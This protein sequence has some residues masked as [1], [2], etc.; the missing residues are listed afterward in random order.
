VDPAA[1]WVS[2]GFVVVGL[3]AAIVAWR[4]ERRYSARHPERRR[5][6]ALVTGRSIPLLIALVV[7]GVGVR[8]LLS[9]LVLPWWQHRAIAGGFVLLMLAT[10]A[11]SV[12]WIRRREQSDAT[13]RVATR[14]LIAVVVLA[15][16]AFGFAGT[17]V[18]SVDPGPS[19]I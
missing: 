5:P 17:P 3:L 13:R 9:D 19:R 11:G 16:L 4:W 2:L 10:T 8:V 12:R 7:A 14:V 18:Q 1:L 6:K 15:V